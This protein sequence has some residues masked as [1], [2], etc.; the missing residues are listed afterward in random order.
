M[1]YIL[2]AYLIAGIATAIKDLQASPIDAP[3]WTYKPTFKM[4]FFV[5]ITWFFWP[6]IDGMHDKFRNRKI[7]F[8]L[9]GSITQLVLL[10][11]LVWISFSSANRITDLFVVHVLIACV[12]FVLL[13]L[14]ALP[15]LTIPMMFV[16]LVLSWPLD[17]LFP[18]PDNGKNIKWCKTCKHF[19]RSKEYED[20]FKGIWR[21]K[22]MPETKILPCR[23]VSETIEVWK[24]YYSLETAKRTLFPTDCP[25]FIQVH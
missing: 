7:A 8:G 11:F 6:I 17:W 23:I 15:L 5:I 20:S 24:S 10:T 2:I 19:N 16:T 21:S 12:L 4:L 3:M 9:F 13:T 18:L 22:V 14:F 1:F 25:S